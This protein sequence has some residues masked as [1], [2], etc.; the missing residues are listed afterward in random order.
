MFPFFPSRSQ[1]TSPLEIKRLHYADSACPVCVRDLQA[2]RLSYMSLAVA[3]NCSAIG[4]GVGRVV[5]VHS[6]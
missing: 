5:K 1:E 6:V 4:D 3:F 2:L